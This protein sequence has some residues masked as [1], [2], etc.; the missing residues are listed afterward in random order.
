MNIVFVFENGT[1]N[2]NALLLGSVT[3]NQRTQI[4]ASL[5]KCLKKTLLH[6]VCCTQYLNIFSLELGV[7]MC[8]KFVP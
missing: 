7:V 8:P 2:A 1:Q 6:I 3:H 4:C 5:H